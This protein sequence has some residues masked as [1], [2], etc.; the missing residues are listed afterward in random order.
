MSEEDDNLNIDLTNGE[1]E[2]EQEENQE[3]EEE[4]NQ[5]E[6]E[7]ENQ[8]EENEQ[9]KTPEKVGKKAEEPKEKPKRARK[10]KQPVDSTTFFKMKAK[11]PKMFQFTA[12]GDLQVPAMDGKEAKVIELPFYIRASK[13]K[14]EEYADQVL[15]D[16]LKNEKEYD[17]TMKNL[18]EALQEW[19][20]TG[21]VTMVLKYQRELQ[22][23]DAER[24]NLK[25]PSR[26]HTKYKNLSIKQILPNSDEIDKKLGY[27]VIITRGRRIHP[28]I[29]YE[30]VGKGEYR[31]RT[32]RGGDVS[33]EESEQEEESQE[34][35]IV[36]Y[37]VADE[38][39]GILSPDT[40]LDIIY[41]GTKYSSATQAYEVERVTALGRK[42]IRP[43]LLRQRNPKMIRQLGARVAGKIE[44]PKKLW[45]SILK[46]LIDQHEDLKPALLDTGN[47]TLVYA[48]PKDK[49]L[50]VGLGAEDEGILDR[51]RW[52]GENILGN[53][54]KAVREDLK[55]EELEKDRERGMVG[56]QR[57]E[58]AL[59]GEKEVGYTEESK[60]LEEENKEKRK[61]Y[62]IG[63]THRR[64]IV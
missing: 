56:G 36:F 40:M 24:T 37:D 29:E 38:E 21:A 25:T 63:L 43:L 17:E 61:G 20:M 53:A 2:E 34:E 1:E 12:E 64:K 54:W 8:E 35:F 42:D 46:A 33:E 59:V 9:P 57:L 6:E 26:W 51:K 55:A 22:R 50:G 7:E 10:M 52:Q 15:R 19:K 13:E 16:L 3:E 47:S 45:I 4:E 28:T 18:Q 27:P 41:N 14:L 11:N 48:D 49:V 60:T 31:E 39:H 30:I 62:F 23:L 44:D 32:R 58:G 5:E